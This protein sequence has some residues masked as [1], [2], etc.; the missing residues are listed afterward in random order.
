MV[1]PSV[2]TIDGPLGL[3]S[4]CRRA[5]GGIGIAI[6]GIERRQAELPRG[7]HV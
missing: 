6:A 7:N 2:L 5:T 3:L 1:M 4:Y